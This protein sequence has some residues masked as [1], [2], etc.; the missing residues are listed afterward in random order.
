MSVIVRHEVE[1]AILRGRVHA[2]LAAT[3]GIHRAEDVIKMVMAG[4]DVTMLCS[5]LLRR[6]IDHIRVIE[7]E[8]KE[9]LQAHE[10]DSL[11]QL[12]GNATQQRPSAFS[13]RLWAERTIRRRGS[14]TPTSTPVIHRP[15][16]GSKPRRL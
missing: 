9:W 7:H 3:S 8:I 11:E 6:G 5:V 4:A 10:Y 15:S 12:K 13:P 14:S 16:C 1:I 2:D